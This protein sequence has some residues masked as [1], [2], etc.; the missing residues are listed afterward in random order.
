MKHEVEKRLTRF[1]PELKDDFIHLLA[2][3][4]VQI[5][6]YTLSESKANRK[7]REILRHLKKAQTAAESATAWQRLLEYPQ[8]VEHLSMMTLTNKL[9]GGKASQID[10]LSIPLV[11][12]P[13][14]EWAVIVICFLNSIPIEKG[15]KDFIEVC[16]LVLEELNDRRLLK[17]SG[18]RTF[19]DKII[20]HHADWLRSLA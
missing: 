7:R 9:D 6:E 1:P 4:K 8:L 2:Y 10:L 3:A 11:K 18:A 19:R 14:Y 15:H 16:Y 12:I 13:P 20:S 5:K 17:R